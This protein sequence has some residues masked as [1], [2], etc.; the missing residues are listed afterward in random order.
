MTIEQALDTA[1]KAASTVTTVVSTR[2]YWMDAPQG[3]ATPYL[4]YRT[5]ADADQQFS[6][7]DKDTGRA[8]VQFDVVGSNKEAKTAL[9]AVRTLLRG[10][11]GTIGS[12]V[13]HII[14]PSNIRE[15]FNPE[16]MRYVFSLDLEVIYSYV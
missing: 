3:T 4:V 7:S 13:V 11:S 10:Q 5:I 2:I 1:L 14:N 12:L 6:F 15:N 8:L 16:S 9:Y